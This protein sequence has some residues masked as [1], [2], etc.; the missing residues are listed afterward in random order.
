MQKAKEY[1]K[2]NG[3]VSTWWSPE[4]GDKSHIFA[5]EIEVIEDMLKQEK[6]ETCLDIACGAGRISQALSSNG[7][8]V[9]S[10]D[11]SLEMLKKGLKWDRIT[12]PILADGENLPFDDDSFDVVTCLD[13]LV[14]FPNPG[15]AISEA[16]RVLKKGGVYICNT[17]NP[18]DLGFIP[19]GISQFLR[20]LLGRNIIPK[21]DGIFRYISP[22]E[23]K[24]LLNLGGLHL[25]EEREVGILAPIKMRCLSGKDSYILSEKISRKLAKLDQLL[26]RTPLVKNL[27]IMSVYKTRK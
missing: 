13:A 21:G 14:H 16:S 12:K 8:R 7:T 2:S 11:I 19:R 3:T 10:L 23:M 17:S 15:L 26:E 18:Y 6:K 4:Q 22:K 25:E 5:R 24:G 20:C 1:F 9:Y 27:A